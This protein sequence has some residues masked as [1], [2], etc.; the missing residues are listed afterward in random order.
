MGPSAFQL[1]SSRRQL[2]KLWHGRPHP[3]PNRGWL[4]VS[5]RAPQAHSLRRKPSESVNLLLMQVTKLE[6]AT[7]RVTEGDDILIIDP[8]SFTVP[9]AELDGVVAVVI[10]HHTPTTSPTEHLA[11]IAQAVPSAPVYAPEGVARALDDRSIRI[12]SPGRHRHGRR[13]RTALLRRHARDHQHQPADR[14][15]RRRARQRPPVLPRRLLCPP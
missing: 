3:G 2:R 12:V 7:L 1:P 15:Q 4:S 11:R 14:R 13:L 5:P 10:T 6:H 8:G 9:L